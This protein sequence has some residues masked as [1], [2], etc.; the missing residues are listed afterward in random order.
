MERA[1]V[2]V[3]VTLAAAALFAAEKIDDAMNWKL[4]RAAAEESRIMDTL[5]E[6]TDRFGARLTGS[7]QLKEAGEWAARQLTS[8]G[9]ENARLEPWDWGHPGWSCERLSVHL[10]APT[11]DALVCEALGWTPGTNGPV[12]GAAVHLV[13]PDRATEEQLKNILAE[14]KGKLKGR[15][16]LVGEWRPVP[17]SFAAPVKRREDADVLAQYDPVNPAP[18]Q[19][20]PQ[21]AAPPAEPPMGGPRPLTAEKAD[22]MINAHLRAEGALARVNNAGREHGQIRAFANRTY[23]VSKAVPTV[24]MRAEDYGRIARLLARGKAVS[25]EIDMRVQTYAEGK[26]AYNVTAEIPGTDKRDEVVML[27]GHL[28]SWHAA[29]GATDNAIGV[30]T[31]MEAV[32]LLKAAGVQPRRTVRIAL[33]SGEEQGLL[34]SKAY[35]KK[36]FGTVEQPTAETARL[37]AY[38][39]IDSGTGRARGMSV[40]GPAAAATVLR[41]A[42]KPFEDLG[43]LGTAA[44]RSR[45]TGGSD[46]T[47]F[48]AAGLAGIGVSQDPIEYGSHTWHTNLDTYERI[49]PEDARKSAIVIAAA[50]YHLAM[51]DEPLPRFQRGDMPPPVADTKPEAA[52]GTP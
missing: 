35:V 9:L 47:S 10:S 19:F 39:N 32:R 27:G 13:P 14:S 37:V 6:L 5:H 43:V 8:W 42:L 16:V 28:D 21:R 51:R 24:V 12:S 40:F 25:L 52:T 15:V 23:N 49:V 7:P 41:E 44:T 50:V 48:N 31:M 36:H 26:T 18:P 2:A 17:V 46:H 11:R 34:G 20:G 22:E 45:R 33:W 30:A 4:R 3:A 38:F 29:T 1:Q